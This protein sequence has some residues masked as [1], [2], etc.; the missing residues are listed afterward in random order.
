[1]K[2]IPATSVLD[3][4]NG[5]RL[6]SRRNTI[7][8]GAS[9]TRSAVIRLAGLSHFPVTAACASPV[10]LDF[11]DKVKPLVS[12]DPRPRKLSR[13]YR[14]TPRALEVDRAVYYLS[15]IHISE[16]TRLGMISYA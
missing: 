8:S 15:L 10:P 4:P 3:I 14:A 7:I 2:M 9:A 5:R 16:P 12:S 6:L 13:L 1:M 11:S